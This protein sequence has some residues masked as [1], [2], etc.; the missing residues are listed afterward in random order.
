MTIY[1]IQCSLISACVSSGIP[2]P[3]PCW[4]QMLEKDRYL[5]LLSRSFVGLVR[6]LTREQVEYEC[7]PD[8]SVGSLDLPVQCWTYMPEAP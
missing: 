7:F 6:K 8:V 3:K 4:P 5:P 1:G 2:E